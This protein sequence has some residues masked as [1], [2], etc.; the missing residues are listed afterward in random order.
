MSNE[1]RLI[2]IMKT[3]AVE[4]VNA[5]KPMEYTVGVVETEP[6][7]LT[8]RISQKLLLTKEFLILS[9]NVTDFTT[10]ISFDNPDV[11]QKILVWDNPQA[12]IQLTGKM[13]FTQPIPH[14]VTVYNALKAG[15]KVI[16][17]RLQGGNK[18]L[19]LDRV[20]SIT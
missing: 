1:A 3:A 12:N 15:D 5:N 4:A 8:I 11:V 14:E 19:V 7:E 10:K 20:V 6:P 17:L 13:S 16:L 18:Y 2:G 9:R